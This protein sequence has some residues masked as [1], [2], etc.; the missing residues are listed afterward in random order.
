[1]KV[2]Y[3]PA[4]REEVIEALRWYVG[5]AGP[6]IA[7]TFERELDSAVRL[8]LRFPRLGTRGPRES[9]SL[10][11]DGFR[12]TLHYRIDGELIRI[13]AV[14]HQSRKPGYWRRRG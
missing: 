4:A 3:E 2:R 8:L 14:A 1:M 12:Y 13:L 6:T 5:V 7:D 9:R 11:L 10:R